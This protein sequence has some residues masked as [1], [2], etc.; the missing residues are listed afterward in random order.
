MRIY[1]SAIAICAIGALT[2][3]AATAASANELKVDDDGAQCPNATYTSIQA[4]VDAASPG[5]KVQVCAGTYME[6]VRIEAKDNLKLEGQDNPTIKAPPPVQTSPRALVWVHNS[7]DVTLRGFTVSG[8]WNEPGCQTERH[9]GVFVDN[10]FD[11]RISHNHVTMIR[12][13]IP[14]L[15]GCQDGIAIEVGRSALSSSGS[16]KIDHNLV[17]LY[18]KGGVLVDFAGSEADITHNEIVG[19]PGVGHVGMITAQNGIQI[20]RGAGGQADHNEVRDNIYAG[21]VL[22]T[23]DNATGVLL[24]ETDAALKI[25]HNTVHNND[26]NISLYDVQGAKIDHNESFD[27]VVY[28][29][30]FADEDSSGNRFEENDAYNNNQFDCEDRSTGTGTAGTA[31]TWKGNKGDTQN[32]PGLCKP[33]HG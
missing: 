27:A 4:A 9:Y 28:D 32:R 19:D 17:D 10:S 14:A 15:W 30:L 21:H 2:L 6:Q 25:D 3:F 5:D 13:A 7:D 23:D 31:N 16:A 11:A 1:R 22:P 29:G 8:P 12:D 33:H 18:Q 20:S 26:D 24:F